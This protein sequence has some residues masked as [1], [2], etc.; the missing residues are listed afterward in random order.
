VPLF[1][2]TSA[3][4][5]RVW[6]YAALTGLCVGELTLALGTWVVAGLLGGA[7]LLLYFYVAAGLIQAMLD[8][9]LNGRLALEY[10][11]VGVVGLILILSTSPWRP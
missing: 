10:G 6:L 7:F 5:P 9:S 8:G 4:L 2:P 1:R 3:P 11:L